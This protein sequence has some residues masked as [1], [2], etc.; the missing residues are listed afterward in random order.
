MLDKN[1]L[2]ETYLSR[3]ILNYLKTISVKVYQNTFTFFDRKLY[4]NVSQKYFVPN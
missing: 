3:K 4:S 2:S 1:I